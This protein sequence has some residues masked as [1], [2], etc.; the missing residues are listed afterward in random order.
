MERRVMR[1]FHVYI[2]TCPNGKRYVDINYSGI[3]ECMWCGSVEDLREDSLCCDNCDQVVFC[4]YC[5]ERIYNEDEICYVGN[6]IFCRYCYD[7]RIRSCDNC[8]DDFYTDEL[9]T[10]KVYV[11]NEDNQGLYVIDYNTAL[12]SNC[13]DNFIKENVINKDLTVIYQD[14]WEEQIY[15][16]NIEDLKPEAISTLLPYSLSKAFKR[17][18]DLTYFRNSIKTDPDLRYYVSYHSMENYTARRYEEL[19]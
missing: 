19:I 16:I 11:N 9:K 14:S 6:D 13:F 1:E 7:E 10:I 18:S 4:S 2:H 17:N 5:G 15:C 12:C 3:S 8:C